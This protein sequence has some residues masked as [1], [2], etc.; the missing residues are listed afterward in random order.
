MKPFDCIS[1][2]IELISREIVGSEYFIA[3]TGA[4]ISTESG[5]PDYRSKG[6]IWDK[7]RPVYIDEFMS[8]RAARVKYWKRK[9]ELYPALIKAQPNAAHNGLAELYEMGS[10]KAV[11]TELLQN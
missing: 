9:A 6:G 7:F 4:G 5:I 2:N 3:F 1:R 11:I 8:S 10:L